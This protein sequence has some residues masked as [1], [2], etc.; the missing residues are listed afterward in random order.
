MTSPGS[1]TGSNVTPTRLQSPSQTMNTYY[2]PFHG[3]QQIQRYNSHPLSNDNNHGGFLHS[4]TQSPLHHTMRYPFTP[5]LRHQRQ[6]PRINLGS[7]SSPSHF[8]SHPSI[9]TSPIAYYCPTSPIAYYPNTRYAHIPTYS[10]YARIP[11]AFNAIPVTQ[12][13]SVYAGHPLNHMNTHNDVPNSH[14]SSS[15]PGAL[16]VKVK[17][18]QPS[19]VSHATESYF[20][21]DG[22]DTIE[23]LN[24]IS[25]PYGSKGGIFQNSGQLP[26]GK[27]STISESKT[28]T[29]LHSTDVP[30]WLQVLVPESL[31]VV[32]PND[33]IR[34]I[35]SGS[36]MNVDLFGQE[37]QTP[38]CIHNRCSHNDTGSLGQFRSEK[39][40]ILGV[41]ASSYCI[42]DLQ[43]SLRDA[44]Q[45][46]NNNSLRINNQI[47]PEQL[48]T[49]G[50]ELANKLH[51][52]L[53][54]LELIKARRS[55]DLQNVVIASIDD[56]SGWIEALL[57]SNRQRYYHDI[58]RFLTLHWF[59]AL[60][61]TPDSFEKSRK[62][63]HQSLAGER[64][65]EKSIPVAENLG[66]ISSLLHP[67]QSRFQMNDYDEKLDLDDD[68]RRL[69]GS[70]VET[71]L[72]FKLNQPPDTKYGGI[73]PESFLCRISKTTDKNYN[74]K[75]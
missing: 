66:N 35:R 2:G 71:V 57:K 16:E 44:N 75:V 5:I 50:E 49:C 3:M 52:G 40:L 15:A 18:S 61:L 69:L 46:P 14:S 54:D 37:I 36:W 23:D 72:E 28:K 20:S 11:T 32:S 17:I 27:P 43:T 51:P 64:R 62:S 55:A 74:N 6:F 73:C 45:S 33:V 13:S 58:T 38:E 70:R 42:N 1:T 9:L 34:A 39:Q 67:T 10:P 65:D 30:L 7:S 22:I 29:V 48:S 25:I 8:S 56:H 59:I 21:N 60:H 31:L 19:Y 12:R 63:H 4:N 47:Y 68:E 53:Q 24:K 41:H 26:I